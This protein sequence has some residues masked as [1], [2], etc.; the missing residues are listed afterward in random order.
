MRTV[1]S[2]KQTHVPTVVVNYQNCFGG[3][4]CLQGR[5]SSDGI[6]SP[7]SCISNHGNTATKACVKTEYLVGIQAGVGTADNNETWADR[8]ERYF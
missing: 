6:Y 5:D 2:V 7:P 3:S 4:D 8:F 1:L